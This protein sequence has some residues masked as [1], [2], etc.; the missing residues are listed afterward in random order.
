MAEKLLRHP[1]VE[2]MG[3]ISDSTQ[4]AWPDGYYY[5]VCP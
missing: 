1:E 5:V 3:I 2:A 4:T